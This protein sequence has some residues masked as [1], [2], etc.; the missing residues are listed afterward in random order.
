MPAIDVPPQPHVSIVRSVLNDARAIPF[1]QGAE[2]Q[3][4][5]RAA[6]EAADHW[7]SRTSCLLEAAQDEDQFTY[8]SVPLKVAGTAKVTY[9]IAGR[10]EP[11]PYSTD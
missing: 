10:L 5:R 11:L 7:S 1:S 4:V 8:D 2:G 3:C 9:R 6:Q